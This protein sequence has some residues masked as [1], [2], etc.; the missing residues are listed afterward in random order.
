MFAGQRNN[1]QKFK[2]SLTNTIIITVRKARL[3]R[4][5]IAWWVLDGSSRGQLTGH[6]GSSRVTWAAHVVLVGSSRVAEQHTTIN[7]ERG[8]QFWEGFNRLGVWD[9]FCLH[10]TT[11]LCTWERER[12]ELVFIAL[13]SRIVR[14]CTLEPIGALFISSNIWTMSVAVITHYLNALTFTTSVYHRFVSNM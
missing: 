12:E 13:M 3:W 5:L 8:K 7:K 9:S 10:Q 1:W 6:V 4:E 2:M 11:R 14:H